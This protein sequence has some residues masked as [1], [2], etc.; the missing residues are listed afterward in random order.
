MVSLDGSELALASNVTVN[1]ADQL[2]GPA[3]AFAITVYL[4]QTFFIISSNGS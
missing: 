4:D 1:G 2:L 3:T